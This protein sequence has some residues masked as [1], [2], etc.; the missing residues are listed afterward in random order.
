[1]RENVIAERILRLV[2]SPDRG[3]CIVGDLLEQ[4]SGPLSFWWNIWRTAFAHVIQDVWHGRRRMIWLLVSGMV[5]YVVVAFAFGTIVIT[6]WEALWPY[7]IAPDAVYIP[8]WGLSAL[9]LALV[10]AV[11]FV[12]AWDVS[13]RS[14]GRE[15]AAGFAFSSGCLI[16]QAMTLLNPWHG[17]FSIA[18]MI[19]Y[20]AQAVCAMAGAALRR[21]RELANGGALTL[22]SRSKGNL[23][24][25]LLGTTV[26]MLM[27]FFAL[28]NHPPGK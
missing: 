21:E 10:T 20:C 8:P 3:S 25:A 17:P 26:V 4:S 28:F 1:M 24:L 22:V 27:V 13:G 18:S 5:E 16:L 12:V 19:A 15:V 23:W 6:V 9:R 14:E 2:T 7:H 11:P